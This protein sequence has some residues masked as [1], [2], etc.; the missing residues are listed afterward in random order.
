MIKTLQNFLIQ[1]FNSF[2]EFQFLSE[3]IV[4]LLNKIVK[5]LDMQ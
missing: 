1:I 5:V 2:S 3:Q 4:L